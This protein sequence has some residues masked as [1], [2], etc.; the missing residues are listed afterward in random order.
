MEPIMDVIRFIWANVYLR[1]LDILVITFVAA[2]LAR[3]ITKKVLKPLA[4]RT[5]TMVD[6]LI[7]RSISW[8]QLWWGVKRTVSKRENSK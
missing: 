1:F 4:L 8:N 2:L 7:V 6:D 5:K 3:L